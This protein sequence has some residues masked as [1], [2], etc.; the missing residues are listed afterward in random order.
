MYQY[1]ILNYLSKMDIDGA[2]VEVKR[3]QI[4]MNALYQK[5]K[6]KVNDNGYLRYL[7]ALVYELD[8]DNDEAAIAYVKAIKAYDEGKMGLP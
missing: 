1:Q 5:D 6:D 7:Q 4:A 2:L 3:S 8:G